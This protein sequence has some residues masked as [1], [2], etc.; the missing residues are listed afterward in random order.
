MVLLRNESLKGRHRKR[1]RY[2]LVCCTPFYVYGDCMINIWL[3]LF[4]DLRLSIF[5]IGRF[6]LPACTSNKQD[7]RQ[8]I[9]L[10]EKK[11]PLDL[12][13]NHKPIADLC[14]KELVPFLCGIPEQK[15]I[16]L[17][18][19]TP[20]AY[21]NNFEDEYEWEY[22]DTLS[23]GDHI[24][25]A[26][27]WPAHA[28]GKF[29]QFGIIRRKNNILKAI[30][31]IAGGCNHATMMCPRSSTLKN[32]TLTYYQNMTIGLLFQKMMDLYPKL[33]QSA[34]NKNTEMLSWGE[35]CYVGLAFFQVTI[36]PDG[37]L[38]NHCLKSF[39]LA[40]DGTDYSKNEALKLYNEWKNKNHPQSLTMGEAFEE[41]LA[42]HA[43]ASNNRTVDEKQLKN[44]L[45]EACFY[46]KPCPMAES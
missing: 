5:L 26:Y 9:P 10:T 15:E 33:S 35:P 28:S 36:L 30:A 32:D 31:W 27:F 11:L 37:T 25:Y 1:W 19:F 20:A 18:T 3:I 45:K 12:M 7:F 39:S 40:L 42:L 29:T 8:A 17:D 38:K 46:A 34:H 21:E 22:V 23:S 44:I 4:C 16:D 2:F 6:L 41:L 24:V 13:Y 43:Y 14:M